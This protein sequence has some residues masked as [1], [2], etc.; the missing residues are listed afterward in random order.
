MATFERANVRE[1]MPVRSADGEK[2]GKVIMVRDQDF[3]IEKGFFFPKDYL[4]RY[5]DIQNIEGDE[6]TLAHGREALRG[7]AEAPARPRR[8]E[9]TETAIPVSREEVE[10]GKRA[11]TTGEVRAEKRVVEEMRE[12]KVPVRREEVTVE[13]RPVEGERRAAPIQEETVAVPVRAEEVE[14][15]KRPVTTEEVVIRK[16]PIEE[17]RRVAEPV[18][19]E[20]VEIR[21]AEEEERRR[22]EPPEGEGPTRK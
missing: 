1:G 11:V 16:E 17:E 22:I 20:E 5:S 6:I 15:R 14:V 2:L 18:R 10:V 12:E 9:V 7:M 13:R 4:V 21:G 3:T 19:R 8:E